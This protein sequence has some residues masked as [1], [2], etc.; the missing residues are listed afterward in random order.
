MTSL[1]GNTQAILLLTAP[2]INGKRES[3]GPRLLSGG[4]YRQLARWLHGQSLS[5]SDLLGRDGDAISQSAEQELDLPPLQPLLGR[6]FQLGQAV[7][8][9]S[10]RGIWVASRADANYPRRFKERLGDAAPPVVYGC[11]EASLLGRGGLAIVGSRNVSEALLRYTAEVARTCAESGYAVVSGGAR[12]VDQAAMQ[13]AGAAEGQVVGVLADSLERAV[14]K[15]EHR[16]P[17]MSGAMVLC[18]PYDPQA[19]FNVGHAMQR[20]KLIYGLADAALVVNA[21]FEKGGTWNGSVEQLATF[22][23][24]PIYVR[25]DKHGNK[26]LDAL[27]RKG[28]RPWPEP[29]DATSFAQVFSQEPNSTPSSAPLGLFDSQD[30]PT[31]NGHSTSEPASEASDAA[32]E[33]EQCVQRL[34]MQAEMPVTEDDLANRLAVTKP[35]ART[36][37]KHFCEKGLLVRRARPVRYELAE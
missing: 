30:T 32:A 33:L 13:G 37:L 3:D 19:G 29:N 7:E 10:R 31:K 22:R 27:L 17:L 18:S 23:Q 28:A 34:I 5:P 15:R 1:S 8:R 2:L 6:G 24:I 36:W 14:I 20:N 25:Q 21:D 9:W 4:A 11:G 35:Q 26:A 16:E 12:G